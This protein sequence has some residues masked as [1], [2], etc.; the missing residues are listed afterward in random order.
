MDVQYLRDAVPPLLYRSLVSCLSHAVSAA[1]AFVSLCATVRTTDDLTVQALLPPIVT[2][3]AAYLALRSMYRTA[4]W[5]VSLVFW[6]AKWGVIL[7]IIFAGYAFVTG[8]VDNLRDCPGGDCSNRDGIGFK[9]RTR[10]SRPRV[11]IHQGWQYQHAQSK[12]SK[13]QQRSPE[14]QQLFN[15][16]N[17]A[18]DF[19]LG[20][21]QWWKAVNGLVSGGNAETVPETSRKPKSKAASSKS[22]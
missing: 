4:A 2:I 12:D 1:N 7:A 13:E 9:Q 8:S 21:N 11:Q 3:L 5:A 6:L 10:P 18:A 16:V 22:R 19:A 14:V 17:K 15:I 20:E